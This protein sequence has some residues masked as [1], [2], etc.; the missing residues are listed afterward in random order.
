MTNYNKR[1]RLPVMLVVWMVLWLVAESVVLMADLLAVW[2]ACVSADVSAGELATKG[3]VKKSNANE[4]E[5]MY[6]Q[7]DDV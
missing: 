5:K 4:N 1:S 7:F 3:K 2:R 6:K